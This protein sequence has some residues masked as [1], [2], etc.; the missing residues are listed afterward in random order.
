MRNWPWVKVLEVHMDK[1]RQFLRFLMG[2]GEESL[3]YRGE[4]IHSQI[5]AN[6][7]G[8]EAIVTKPV[9]NMRDI[10]RVR[11]EYLGRYEGLS[12]S[13]APQAEA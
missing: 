5:L 11:V 1:A 3:S 2:Q 9:E 12:E 4:D 13:Q 8:T 6:A 7:F 10:Y